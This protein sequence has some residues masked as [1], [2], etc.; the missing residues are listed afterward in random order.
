MRVVFAGEEA[1]IRLMSV[2][3]SHPFDELMQLPER[4]IR[5]ATAALLF[6]RDA[7]PDIE[8]PGYLAR[9]DG[10]AERVERVAGRSPFERIAALRRVICDECGFAGNRDD[11]Y[12]P[13]NSYLNEVLDRRRGI[14]ISLSAVWLDVARALSYPLA[15]VNF[16]G[17]FLLRYEDASGPIFIDAFTGGEVL[18][19]DG[20]RERLCEGVGA[21]RTIPPQF[22]AAAGTK[23]V[24]MR[25]LNNLLGIYLQRC[26]WFSAEPVLA[27][28][29]A[30][31]PDDADLWFRRGQVYLRLQQCP[32]AVACFERALELTGCHPGAVLVKRHLAAAKKQIAE[33]N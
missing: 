13:R 31:C 26:D 17:H 29:T 1:I 8:I 3:P 25:M 14:P 18:D 22:L 4:D 15:G 28:Q 24:L 5:L 7:Y 6:A 32:C 33:V 16:P 30:L 2:C 20:L 12:D 9:L 23:A 21:G 11:Y 27:R 10:L 19:A